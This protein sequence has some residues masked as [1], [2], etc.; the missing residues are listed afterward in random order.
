MS[1]IK[2]SKL[3]ESFP[4]FNMNIG[5]GSMSLYLGAEP[6][7]AYDTIW[8]KECVGEWDAFGDLK[9]NPDNY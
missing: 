4:N 6:I 3:A 8:F 2:R 5:A 9:F 1:L 7:F